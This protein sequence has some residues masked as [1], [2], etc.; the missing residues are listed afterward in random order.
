MTYLP[1]IHS[2]KENIGYF[3]S[4]VENGTLYIATYNKKIAGFIGITSGWINHL[5]IDKYFQNK[6]V[7]KQLVTFAKTHSTDGLNLW[8]FE[9]NTK[10][11]LF[12][13]REE[14]KLVEKRDIDKADN[15][16][17]LPDRK[18]RWIKS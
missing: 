11:I 4:Q 18:Y 1:K 9:D 5:Y 2:H 15:E 12:Y 14:F 10:A 13:E 17:K 8:V 7:G 3:K 16:E 6:G